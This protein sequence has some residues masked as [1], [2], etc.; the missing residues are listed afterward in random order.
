MV[1]IFCS[2]AKELLMRRGKENGFSHEQWK[3]GPWLVRV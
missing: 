2:S 1:I 3:K